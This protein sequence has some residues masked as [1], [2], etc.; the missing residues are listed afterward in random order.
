MEETKQI[1]YIGYEEQSEIVAINI[2][3]AP[4]VSITT[5]QNGTSRD[6]T[7]CTANTQNTL[8][9][10]KINYTNIYHNP[11]QLS[12]EDFCTLIHCTKEQFVEFVDTLRLH[13]HQLNSESHL[14]LTSRA[15]LFRIKLASFE[16]DAQLGVYLS[17]A[18]KTANNIY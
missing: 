8:T 4:E 16:S 9:K 14:S 10:Q 3:M 12:N 6:Q 15:F 11:L 1:I 2:N 13:Y 5:Q 17:V 7:N 18:K